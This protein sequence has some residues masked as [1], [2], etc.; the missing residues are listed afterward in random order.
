MTVGFA[1]ISVTALALVLTGLVSVKP[2]TGHAKLGL[3]RL[4][5]RSD[6]DG[7]S[8]GAVNWH[9]CGEGYADNI[10]CAEIAVPLDY[11]NASDGTT[12]TLAVA[13]L[14]AS[15]QA[16]RCVSTWILIA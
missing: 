3:R 15:D 10:Q 9:S 6:P 2:W 11:R 14:L 1:K 8:S 12:I 13:R 16:N 5:T 4:V 7:S